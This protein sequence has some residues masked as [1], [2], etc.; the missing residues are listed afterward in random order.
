[1]IWLS[2]FVSNRTAHKQSQTQFKSFFRL[3]LADKPVTLKNRI[4]YFWILNP[5]FQRV[6]FVTKV[7]FG[8]TFLLWVRQGSDWPGQRLIRLAEI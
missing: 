1:M 7:F 6:K 8:F 5:Y 4:K 3:T 2:Q